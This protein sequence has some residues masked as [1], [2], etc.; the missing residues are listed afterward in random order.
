MKEDVPGDHIR[1]NLELLRRKVIRLETATNSSPAGLDACYRDLF[2][3]SKDVIY[4]TSREG[5][6]LDMNKAGFELFGYSREEMIGMDIGGLYVDL[7]DREKFMSEIESSG[8]VKDYEVTFRR[9]DGA[10]LSCLLTSTLRTA[11]DGA[12]VGYHGI[13]RDITEVKKA[14]EALKLS[15]RK[16]SLIFHSSPE[17]IAIST[18]KEGRMLDVNEAFLATT[19]YARDEVIGKTSLELGLWVDPGERAGMVK[20]LRDRGAIR[21]HE[22]LFRL[23][24]GEVRTVLR[25]AELVELDG[26]ECVINVTRDI[27]ERKRAE[28]EIEKLNEELARRVS[29]LQDA[30]R[31]LDAFSFSVS[32]DLKAPLITVGG[33]AQRLLKKYQDVLDP[34]GQDMLRNIHLNV[35][36]MENLIS[37]LLS[38]SRSGRQKMD[39][40]RVDMEDLIRS[41]FRDLMETVSGR[42]VQLKL[43]PL[44]AAYAD[45][46]L[47]RQV[48]IN[49]LSNS[50]KFTRPRDTGLIEVGAIPG[51]NSV[52]YFIKDNGVGFD[53]AQ[54]DKLFEAFKRGHNSSDFEGTGI[55]LSI[56]NRIITRHG[57]TL[58]AE[59][60]TG[61]GATFY[62]E[63]PFAKG[64]KG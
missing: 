40:S 44:P 21:D 48:I 8:A 64:R 3:E 43:Q 56:V 29:E 25:S 1:H 36:K 32:H 16:F 61:E 37:D 11:A 19:G 49:L 58:R 22:T 45:R 50:I 52:V 57:G 41:A 33:F 6:I 17:W 13:I 62:F 59:A 5:E 51:N 12:V 23:K 34:A 15:E 28:K 24:S 47:I 7:N 9:K 35:R 63:L 20:L 38:L 53:M 14:A 46:S 10:L 2:G 31:E 4:V 27:T 39:L 18:L 60:K 42:D 26:E 55:G 30:N 54:A